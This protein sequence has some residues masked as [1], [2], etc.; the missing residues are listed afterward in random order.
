M[1]N[2]YKLWYEV[3]VFDNGDCTT[4]KVAAGRVKVLTALTEI[5]TD[6]QF[7]RAYYEMEKD[8]VWYCNEAVSK[9]YVAANE[10]RPVWNL[11]PQCIL[12][13]TVSVDSENVFTGGV[14]YTLACPHGITSVLA[15]ECYKITH[16]WTTL[17]EPLA[18]IKN[19]VEQRQATNDSQFP[20]VEGYLLLS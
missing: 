14:S 6:V 3:R 19:Y 10:S 2:D 5:H 13:F 20:C 9:F 15:E 12:S 16:L 4:R 8:A 18:Y 1:Q 17:L 11:T 7:H